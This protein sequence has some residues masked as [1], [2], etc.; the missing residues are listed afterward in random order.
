[1]NIL[2]TGPAPSGEPADRTACIREIEEFPGLLKSTL[3]RLDESQMREKTLPGNWT[4][5]QVVHHI[6]D[7]HMNA[8]IRLKLALTEQTPSIKPYD[9]AAWAL[10]PDAD[11]RTAVALSV[12]ILEGLHARWASLLYSLD[13]SAWQR[14]YFHPEQKKEV[15]L[16]EYAASYAWHGKNHLAHIHELMTARGW[17]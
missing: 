5:A 12:A 15:K 16:S 6:A 17:I 7:S 13:D 11:H 8:F 9:E 3:S 2:K 10:L 1:M 14:A 4:V